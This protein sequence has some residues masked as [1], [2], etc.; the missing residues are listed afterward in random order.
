MRAT[1][2]MVRM[3]PRD[4]IRIFEEADELVERQRPN[5]DSKGGWREAWDAAGAEAPND[6]AERMNRSISAIED[7]YPRWWISERGKELESEQATVEQMS[8]RVRMPRPIDYLAVKLDVAGS[9]I[10]LQLGRVGAEIRLHSEDPYWL[11]M[12]HAWAVSTLRGIT[13]WYSWTVRV[14]AFAT[15]LVLSVASSFALPLVLHRGFGLSGDI[16]Q[17]WGWPVAVLFLVLAA[18]TQVIPRVILKRPGPA[19]WRPFVLQALA[20]FGSGVVGWL[21]ARLGD[22]I[23]PPSP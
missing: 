21:I 11:T 9:S 20:M 19:R 15:L 17:Q 1:T 6:L 16:A 14:W 13:P 12:A 10:E 23:L 5:G 3:S 4:L 2:P 7:G 18:L 8:K 22:A